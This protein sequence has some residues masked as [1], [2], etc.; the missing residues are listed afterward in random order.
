MADDKPV[1]IEKPDY[2]N[3]KK[4][5]QD[6]IDSIAN[7]EYVDDDFDHY[8]YETAIETFFGKE[9]W[10]FINRRMK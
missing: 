5:C 1:M 2:T 9:V 10:Q 6:Y 4:I 8:I 3:L 7:N